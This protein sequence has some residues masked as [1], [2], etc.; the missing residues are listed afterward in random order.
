MDEDYEQFSNS[1]S[2]TYLAFDW[3]LANF[4]LALLIKVLLIKVLLIKKCEVDC[5]PLS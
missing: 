1:E 4:S 5:L 3:F 2:S